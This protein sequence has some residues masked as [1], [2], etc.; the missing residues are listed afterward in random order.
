MGV[1][2]LIKSNFN[3]YNNP[4]WNNK[5]NFKR[6]INMSTDYENANIK[7]FGIGGGGG[8]AVSYMAHSKIDGVTFHYINTDAQA[9]NSVP[10]ENRIQI[11]QEITRGLGAGAKPEIGEQ[12]A[13]ESREQIAKALEGTDMV[14]I[15]AGMGGGTGTGAAPVVASIAREL[16]ILTVGVVTTPFSFEGK[17]RMNLAI[18]GI[19]SLK[20]HVDSLITIP[21]ERLQSV[22]G[23]KV[24]LVDAFNQANSILY[25]AVQGISDLIIRPGMINVDFA[26][27]RTV[28]SEMGISMMGSGT[29]SGE[30]RAEKATNDA[31]YSPLLNNVALNQARGILINV[32][33]GPDLSLGEFNT[34]GEMI[35]ELASPEATVVV[36]TVIDKDMCDEI[37]VTLVA[38]GLECDEPEVKAAPTSPR[39]GGPSRQANDLNTHQQGHSITRAASQ[40]ARMATP[41]QPRQPEKSMAELHKENGV[42]K[43]QKSES[44][45]DIP[46]FLRRQNS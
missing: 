46:A 22:L 43:P 1:F 14:F 45:L 21:N 18:E 6:N 42:T 7:V 38:T 3:V 26:D 17:K 35:E 15:T 2:L 28:M 20:G 4:T 40:P 32:T 10:E 39:F 27:V 23:S 41:S 24:S 31:I 11:G 37:R 9:L 12:S 30:N 5:T 36:G 8:N 25:N 13:M 19:S 34:I 44:L 29:A 33:S 16:G